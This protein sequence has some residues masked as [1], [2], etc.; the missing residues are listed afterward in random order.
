MKKSVYLGILVVVA[1]LVLVFNFLNPDEEVDFSSQIKPILNNNCIVCHGGVKKNSGFSLLFEEEALGDTKSGKP[2]IIP[3]DASGSEL[4]RRIKEDDPELR[5]P[6]EKPKLSETEIDLLTRWIDQGAKWGE[7]WAYTLPSKINV[8]AITEEAGFSSTTSSNFLKNDIDHFILRKL[9][10]ADILPNGPAE[11]EIIVRRAAL[12]ITGLPPDQQLFDLWMDGDINYETMVDSLLAKE[13]YG[14]KWA[15]WWLDMARY[16]DT[17]GYEK[18]QGRSIYHYRDWVIKS[19]NKDMPFDQ[20]TI[21]Q[22]AGDLL[23]EPSIDQYIA[24]AFHRNTMNNDEGGTEDEEY[25]VA[26]VIDRV[27]TTFEVW[28]STTIGCVQ[29]HSHPYDPFKNEEYYSLMAFFDNSRDEDIPSEAPVLKLYNPAQ[30][31]KVNKVTNWIAKHES[32]LA[33]EEYKKFMAYIEP[34]H[35]AHDFKDFENGAYDDH[36]ALNLWDDGSCKLKDITT[37]G[38]TALYLKYNSGFNGTLLTFRK[39]NSEGEILARLNIDKTTTSIIKKIHF[40]KIDE[41]FDLYVETNNDAVAKDANVIDLYWVTFMQEI[42]GSKKPGYREIIDD[43]H[44]VL[45]AKTSTVPIMIENPEHMKRT[46]QVFERG[47]W[48]LKGDTVQPSTPQALN[49]WN[50]EVVK[51]SLRAF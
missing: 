36:A 33:A 34:V 20:F 32:N 45:N 5:M 14:E 19:L 50:G 28:Q 15:S 4:I 49:P 42:P 8:P 23:P 6:Y 51:R 21:E 44:T 10:N 2:A 26:A 7:H 9:T 27:N 43:L 48:L 41:K 46:T 40:K 37:D 18:D 24:T 11:K 22:L 3:G 35:N 39:N 25:R 47:N 1:L 38:G 17:K 29:C 12:D 31:E 13:S 30:Q 16:S